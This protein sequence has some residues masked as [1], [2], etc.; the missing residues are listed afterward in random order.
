M[1]AVSMNRSVDLDQHRADLMDHLYARSG[2]TNGLYTGLWQQFCCEIVSQMRDAGNLPL[3]VY[4]E[5]D[6]P[7][8][9]D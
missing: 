3:Y 6:V 5:V 9:T 1:T 7:G 8:L 2:R 4:G